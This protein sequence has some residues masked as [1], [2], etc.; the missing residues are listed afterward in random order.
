MNRRGFLAS[1][2]VAPLFAKLAQAKPVRAVQ[3]FRAT[4]AAASE[5]SRLSDLLGVPVDE[6][7]NYKYEWLE[8]HAGNAV[9]TLY[10]NFTQIVRTPVGCCERN[11]CTHG[12][13]WHR[14][15][16]LRRH[17]LTIREVLEH[18]TRY[19]SRSHP[20][21]TV[22]MTGGRRFW[23]QDYGYHHPY[24]V[25]A[26]RWRALRF[27]RHDSNIGGEWLSDIGYRPLRAS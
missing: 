24:R 19:A 9:P 23:T 8:M 1:L 5:R 15:D 21:E 12:W 22:T 16:A 25:M 10:Y 4:R 11:G 7:S 27:H 6:V 17:V 13:Q 2:A 18:S 20:P 26:H 14:D 3:R